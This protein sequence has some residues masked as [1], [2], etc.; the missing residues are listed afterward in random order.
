MDGPAASAPFCPAWPPAGSFAISDAAPDPERYF[1]SCT[2]APSE[3]IVGIMVLRPRRSLH[4]LSDSSVHWLIWIS[5]MPKGWYIC[6]YICIYMC[7]CISL[8]NP[9]M[10]HLV[11]LAHL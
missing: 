2:Q 8:Y 4:S 1:I 7:V 5:T 11:R 3:A 6:I 9:D 10:Q